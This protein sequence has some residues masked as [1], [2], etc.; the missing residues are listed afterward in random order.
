MPSSFDVVIAGG[1]V[2]GSSVAAVLAGNDDFS[3]TIAVI[4]RD[5]TYANCATTRSLGGIRQQFSTPENIAMT[6]FGLHFVRNVGDYLA[7]DGEAPALSFHEH[8]YLFL[9]GES[10]REVLAHNH[11]VQRECGAD[12]ELLT[13]PELAA[14]FPWINADELVGASFGRSGEGWIDPYALLQGFRR[15]ARSLGVTYIEDEVV[16]IEHDARRVSAVRLR[17]GD[18]LRA[19][20]LVN[21]AGPQAGYLAALAGIDLPV[22]PR[23]RHVFVFA[24]RETITRCPLVIDPSG[25]YF[26]PE[27][28]N[29]LTGTSPPAERDPDSDDLLLDESNFES[30]LWP[31]LA[32]RVPAFEAIK[33]QSGWAGHYDFN[34]VDQNG[35]IGRHPEVT[36]LLFANGFSG[37]GLQQSPATG[38][39]V[40][41]LITYGGF[42]SIDL[43]RFR[44]ERFAECQ[45]VFEQAVV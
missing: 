36:N 11:A 20:S 2:M 38:R 25:V 16:A 23:K 5:S 45:P 31:V 13:P 35:I 29:F 42:R 3:G 30:E 4:E 18:T 43:T 28:A 37:H 6:R 24:C 33:V 1:G 32:T 26:R 39:A 8:G 10:G 44:Y 14:K 40:S 7:V 21:A 15:K 12:V 27:G 17:G 9:A 41:E 34:T 19:G 22:R